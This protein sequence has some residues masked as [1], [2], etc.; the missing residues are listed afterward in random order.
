M[1]YT[2]LSKPSLYAHETGKVVDYTVLSKPSLYAH[3]TGKVVD[4]C[5]MQKMEEEGPDQPGV[6]GPGKPAMSVLPTTAAVHGSMVQIF[7]RSLDHMI[8][9]RMHAGL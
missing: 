1:D 9:T 2:V 6:L 7:S 5:R 8:G 3:E 4:L